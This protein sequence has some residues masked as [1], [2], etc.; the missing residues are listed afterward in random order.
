MA[1]EKLTAI[2]EAE[3]AEFKVD[4]KT[5]LVTIPEEFEIIRKLTKEDQEA[6]WQD[7]INQYE[8]ET[9]PSNEELIELG[10]TMHPYYEHQLRAIEL[11]DRLKI[12]I[13]EPI[14][15]K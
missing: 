12:K 5:G 13:T 1:D 4:S 8:S 9:E 10:K 6:I 11:K 7:E 3:L 2:T 15:I 14:V